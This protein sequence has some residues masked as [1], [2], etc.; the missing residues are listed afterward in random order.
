V[1]VPPTE[2]RSPH[3]RRSSTACFFAAHC[4]QLDVRAI[5]CLLGRRQ[6]GSTCNTVQLRNVVRDRLA[7]PAAGE[8]SKPS[9]APGGH[10]VCTTAHLAPT[11]GS[12]RFPALRLWGGGFGNP[13]PLG[14]AVPCSLGS[15]ST[16]D[17]GPGTR[18]QGGRLQ[19]QH[20]TD[21][22]NQRGHQQQTNSR[23]TEPHPN[24]HECIEGS[25]V[26]NSRQPTAG[27]QP[28]NK[29]TKQIASS[30]NHRAG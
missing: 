6:A 30:Y 22:G 7:L 29:T 2:G 28:T 25:E 27:S 17:Q 4:A 19:T 12:P 13:G 1:G 26:R 23:P 8:H 5:A 9:A 10:S 18:V 15:L 16:G 3:C 24:N 14:W 21:D 11:P 20:T